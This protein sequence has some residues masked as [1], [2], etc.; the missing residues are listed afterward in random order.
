MA[1]GGKPGGKKLPAKK[2]KKRQR[3][4]S[5]S[6][7]AGNR[8]PAHALIRVARCPDLRGHGRASTFQA[9]VEASWGCGGRAGRVGDCALRPACLERPPSGNVSRPGNPKGRCRRATARG[10]W[11]NSRCAG[12]GDRLRPPCRA[13]HDRQ[14]PACRCRGAAG[15]GARR[16]V[17]LDACAEGLRACAVAGRLAVAPPASADFEGIEVYT[18]ALAQEGD[19]RSAL[20]FADQLVSRRL[21][22]IGPDSLQFADALAARAERRQEA[23]LVPRITERHRARTGHPSRAPG[24][25]AC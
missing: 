13:R 16:P 15:A 1:P 11:R 2:K 22:R 9:T 3:R 5:R 7:K 6:T 23:A 14:D 10:P 8:S 4:S 17:G 19:N 18:E 25:A 12:C 21:A 20:L 24:G